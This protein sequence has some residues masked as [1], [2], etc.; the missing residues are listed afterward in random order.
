MSKKYFKALLIAAS[1]LGSGK[2]ITP[3]HNGSGVLVVVTVKV[4][5]NVPVGITVTEAV[6]VEEMVAVGE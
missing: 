2:L 3:A 1:R 5:V 4:G 6:S